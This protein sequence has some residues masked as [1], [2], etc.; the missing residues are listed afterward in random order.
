MEDGRDKEGGREG[1]RDRDQKAKE[2]ENFRVKVLFRDKDRWGQLI[3]M[4]N[5]RQSSINNFLLASSGK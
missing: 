1:G 3:D 4:L 2:G 5:K